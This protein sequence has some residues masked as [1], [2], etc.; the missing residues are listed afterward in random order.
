MCSA[1]EKGVE[2]RKSCFTQFQGQPIASS[3]GSR[4]TYLFIV[5]RGFIKL[6]EELKEI[7]G[8]VGQHEHLQVS[9][10]QMKTA[11]LRETRK[12]AKTHMTSTEMVQFADKRSVP[13]DFETFV[14]YCSLCELRLI[15]IVLVW[16]SCCA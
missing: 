4:S 15:A 2:K 10:V 5:L 12:R 7:G 11:A 16:F 9:H 3:R 8:S 13:I 6:V 14:R 1:G